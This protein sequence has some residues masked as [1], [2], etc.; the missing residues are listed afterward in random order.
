MSTT[1]DPKGADAEIEALYAEITKIRERIT[2]VRRAAP[3]CEVQDYEFATTEGPV[4][5]SQL[6]R[7]KRDLAVVHNMGHRCPMCTMWADGLNGLLR[8]LDDRLAF[9][10]ST[11]DEP[12]RQR[13]FAS[14]RGWRFRM[15]STAGTTFAADMGYED[16][17]KHPWPGLSMF[18]RDAEGRLVRVSHT[19]F[20]PGDD[21]CPIFHLMDL[22]PEGQDGW[23]PKLA[24][25][26][27]P[28]PQGA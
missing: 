1:S 23:W 17:K 3:P 24:Y 16:E 8:H 20:G 7:G 10:V 18:R 27:S 25:T 4:R 5:L 11:P 2:A 28:N 14:D 22:L 15:V 26:E 6:F 21:F 13:A 9:V 19:G 12:E